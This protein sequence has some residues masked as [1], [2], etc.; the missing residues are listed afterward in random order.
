M[1]AST[2]LFL[3]IFAFS[4]FNCKN[5]Q[6]ETS[7]KESSTAVTQEY[8]QLKIY[9]FESKDQVAITDEFLKNAYLPGL[10]RLG[11]TKVGVFKLRA[12]E[13][14]SIQKTFV[15]T[16]FK[17]IDQFLSLEENLRKDNAYLE[18]GSSY[19]NASYDQIPYQRM[20]S[21]I[22]KAFA[23]M[24][25]MRPSALNGPK[26]E[27]IYEL[28]SYQSPTE[29]Y[30]RNKVAMFNEGGEVKLFDQLKFNAVF[31]G[32]VI[33]GA[34]MPNLM[35]MT[36][37]SNEESR[38]AHWK[39]FVEAPEWKTLSGNPKYKNNVSHIDISFLYPT[40]YSDY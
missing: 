35:Y 28:R 25:I 36:T 37:F 32:E 2:F 6:M 38:T 26:S 14:D 21:I 30:H 20:E 33:S 8:Y 29:Q 19:I 5:T 12:N 3:T 39:T 31:Y 9:S 11:L 13:K 1:K 7:I 24:P 23:D 22:L 16:P 17:N 27:R 18:A 40:D 4:V 10:K 15:L 34:Q